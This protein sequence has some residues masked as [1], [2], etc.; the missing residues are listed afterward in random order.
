MVCTL[1]ASAWTLALSSLSRAAASAIASSG[2]A[3]RQSLASCS[4][5]ITFSVSS[6]ATWVPPTNAV[7]KELSGN[8]LVLASSTVSGTFALMVSISGYQI[9]A[10][11]IWPATNAET[12]VAGS[13]GTFSMS[14]A[15]MPA[16]RSAR[17]S[18]MSPE[19]PS[20][21]P[22]FLPLSCC[23]VV[24]PGL[25]MTRSAYASVL[26]ATTLALPDAGSHM[27]PGPM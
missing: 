25:A 17:L 8:S 3:A 1:A 12:T 27:A 11:S 24:M 5:L 20:G 6:G 23:M 26:I 7:G 9:P 4:T 16:L 13:M 22:T 14:S 2:W 19:V 21:T 18:T 15:V 10:P